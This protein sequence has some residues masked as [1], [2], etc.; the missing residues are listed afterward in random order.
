MVVLGA[1]RGQTSLWGL[2]ISIIFESRVSCRICS[3]NRT[4]GAD[5]SRLAAKEWEGHL[6]V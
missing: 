1:L 2:G 3:V 6:Q 4:E 5:C